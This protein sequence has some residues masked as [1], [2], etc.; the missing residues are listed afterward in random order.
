MLYRKQ[1]FPEDGELV[2]CTV[3]K[4]HFHTV[5]I[6]LDE[7]DRQGVIHISEISPGRIRNI[8]DYVKEGKKVICKVL[9]INKERGHIDLSLRRVTEMQRRAKNNEIKQEQLAEKIVEQAAK[10]LKKN[11]HVFYDEITSKVFEKYPTLFEC[12][13][14]VALGNAD[15]KDFKINP[16][17]IKELEDLIKQ[18]IKPKEVQIKGHFEV[19][20]YQPDGVGLVKKTFEL[21]KVENVDTNYL[22]GG[23]YSLVITTTDYKVGEKILE[24]CIDKVNSFVDENDGEVE[25]VREQN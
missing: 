24:K 2:I 25:F 16:K 11:L 6:K 3:G 20:F 13:N 4:V 19:K 9:R 5:F 21:V 10:K 17:E 12:F 7:Y 23:K 18:R 22:G 15:L 8:R 1:G 14:D